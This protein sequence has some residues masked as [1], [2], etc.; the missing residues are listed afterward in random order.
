VDLF[1]ATRR[2]EIELTLVRPEERERLARLPIGANPDDFR[3]VLVDLPPRRVAYLR[4]QNPYANPG[5]VTGA[6]AHLVEWARERGLERGSWLG[7]QWDDPEI[8]PL[9]RCRYDIGVVVPESVVVG[10]GVSETRF[11]AMKV[12]EVRIAGSLELEM[13]ALDWLYGTW[14]PRS[15]FAPDHQPCFEAYDGMPFA[16]GT[17]HFR[18]RIQ[19][20]VVDASRPL[21]LG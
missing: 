1:R 12:A 5:R 8:V 10:A 7:Y 21:G 16:D 20:P 19:L 3:V 2:E 6:A 9:D 11:A 4:V 17:S 13:R 18:L 14:L 15:G